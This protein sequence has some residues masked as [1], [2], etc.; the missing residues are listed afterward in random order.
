[1]ILRVKDKKKIRLMLKVCFM[2]DEI[3]S[4]EI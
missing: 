2:S 1:M 4:I 3:I